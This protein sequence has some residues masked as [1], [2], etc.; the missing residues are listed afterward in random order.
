MANRPLS[1]LDD[2]NPL[3]LSDLFLATQEGNSVKVTGQQ[4][5]D[6][7]Q[8][9]EER[10]LVNLGPMGKVTTKASMVLATLDG[11][12][13]TITDLIPDNSLVLGVTTFNLDALSG[14]TSYSAGV[15]GDTDR[16][17]TGIG[18]AANVSNIGIVTPY[19][20]SSA[21]SIILTADSGSGSGN[22]DK[23]RVVAFFIEFETPLG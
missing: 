3:S 6:L 23:I 14:I 8:T 2:A 11:T 19:P 20:V 18:I 13:V 22:T 15:S 5:V 17:G 21:Q 10:V 1:L 12:S 16:F 4:I 7:T 9:L